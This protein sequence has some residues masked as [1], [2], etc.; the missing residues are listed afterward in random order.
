MPTLSHYIVNTANFR[1]WAENVYDKALDLVGYGQQKTLAE[2][3]AAHPGQTLDVVDDATMREMIAKHEASLVTEPAPID[4]ERH[5]YLLEVLPPCRWH[6]S[7]G[8]SLFHIS[9]RLTGNLV[10]W[11]AEFHGD[12]FEFVDFADR[13]SEELAC[14]V[15]AAWPC[16]APKGGDA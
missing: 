7:A 10:T 6:S 2:Y 15:L 8:V 9:E 11:A 14:K 16:D 1:G 12:C 5:T 3:R 13:P 4:R